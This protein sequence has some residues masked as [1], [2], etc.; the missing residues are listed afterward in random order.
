LLSADGAI[1]ELRIVYYAHDDQAIDQTGLINHPHK[2][3]LHQG[4]R[5]VGEFPSLTEVFSQ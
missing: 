2:I 4:D 5:L 3:L 1:Q